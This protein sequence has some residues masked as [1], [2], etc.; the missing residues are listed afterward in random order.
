VANLSQ[1]WPQHTTASS[2][3]FCPCV[4]PP[5]PC[6]ALFES[7]LLFPRAAS[8]LDCLCAALPRHRSCVLPLPPQARAACAIDSTSLFFSLPSHQSLKRSCCSGPPLL[9]PSCRRLRNRVLSCRWPNLPLSCCLLRIPHFFFLFSRMPRQVEPPLASP[10]IS[11]PLL[12][13]SVFSN[14]CLK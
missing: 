9:K 3:D 10:P 6:T 5:H 12:S 1:S 14:T 7:L 2:L 4:A 13:N 8:G 11:P